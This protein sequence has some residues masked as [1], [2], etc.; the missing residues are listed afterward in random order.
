MM[1][2]QKEDN[3]I[4]QRLEDDIRKYLSSGKDIEQVPMGKSTQIDVTNGWAEGFSID[5]NVGFSRK[6]RRQ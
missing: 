4:K 6:V 5:D 2:Y 1:R 3:A